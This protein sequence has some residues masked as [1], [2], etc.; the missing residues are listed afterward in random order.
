MVEFE[1]PAIL[2]QSNVKDPK[3]SNAFHNPMEGESP[4]HRLSISGMDV[5]LYDQ[6]HTGVMTPD[7]HKLTASGPVLPFALTPYSVTL[8]K[9]P[10]EIPCFNDKRLGQGNF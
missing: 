5:I 2:R 7:T 1:N 6:T 10:R 8:G 4:A 3:R 9:L